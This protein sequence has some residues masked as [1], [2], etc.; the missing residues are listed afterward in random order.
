MAKQARKDAALELAEIK[1]IA[2][3]L[4]KLLATQNRNS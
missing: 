4:K 3:D 2:E 1:Q